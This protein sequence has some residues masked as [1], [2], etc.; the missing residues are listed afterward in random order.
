MPCSPV[1]V[2][3]RRM[4]RFTMR[5]LRRSASW[6]STGLCASKVRKVWKLP[7][8]T[9]PTMGARPASRLASM[10]ALVSVT[11]SASR[12]TGTHTSVIATSISGWADC[13]DQS[14]TFRACQSLATSLGSDAQRHP[15]APWWRMASAVRAAHS[16]TASGDP[17]NL[18]KSVGATAWSKPDCSLITRIMPSSSSST[19]LTST[20]SRSKRITAAAAS[21]TVG[22][23]ATAT[24]V[25]SGRGRSL[26]VASVMTARVPSEPTRSRARS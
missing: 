2:P 20:P 4:A 24:A 26:S 19:Q 13:A 17:A 23:A 16:F 1:H 15:S 11:A 3:P 14:A 5:S 7:S 18:K 25:V 6:L 22:N 12:D 9:W 8:P 21:P 10:S